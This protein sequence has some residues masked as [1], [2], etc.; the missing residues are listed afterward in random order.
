[1]EKLKFVIPNNSHKVKAQEYIEE[2]KIY[3]SNINGSG[4]LEKYNDYEKWLEFLNEISKPKNGDIPR[5]TFFV[6][7]ECDNKIVGMCNIRHKLNDFLLK[8]YGNI[9]YSVRPTERN[10]GYAN[11]ILHLALTKCKEIGLRKVLLVCAKNNIASEKTIKH[12]G[13]IY[14][15]KIDTKCEG[16][17]TQ[18][19]WIYI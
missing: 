14:W 17:D 10:K 3:N 15:N 11:Q 8:E 18:R 5:S 1:M 2:F 16:K 12:N 6:I 7:R 13:G 9:G 19:Y 4:N